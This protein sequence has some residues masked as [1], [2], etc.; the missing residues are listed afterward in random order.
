MEK[1]VS[2]DEEE[3]ELTDENIIKH[4]ERIEKEKEL[5]SQIDEHSNAYERKDDDEWL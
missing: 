3:D 4:Y 5:D 1:E 2:D